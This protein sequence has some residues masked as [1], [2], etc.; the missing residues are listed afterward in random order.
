MNTKDFENEFLTIY[1]E[2]VDAIFR[3]IAFRLSDRELAKDLSQETFTKAWLYL[4]KNTDVKNAR[5]LLYK[6]AQNLIIDNSRK[7]KF[8]S[9]DEL[10]EGGFDPG[11]SEDE[12]IKG[13]LD[14]Q[15]SLKALD[16]LE[17]KYKEVIILR[18]VEG[19]SPKEIGK[20]LN[21]S[22]NHISVKIHRALKQLK[23]L[24]KYD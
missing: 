18:Y 5:A 17:E 7:K 15:E 6:I 1:N 22:E 21:E 11:K 10:M 3:F 4:S 9:L 19:Y 23:E 20:I 2:N 8:L 13:S 16:K 14:A 24:I 12:E